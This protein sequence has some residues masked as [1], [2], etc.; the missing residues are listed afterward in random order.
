MGRGKPP[1]EGGDLG[2][3]LL[4]G[5]L[6]GGR[7]RGVT[8][9]VEGAALRL[10]GLEVGLPG[11]ELG[12]GGLLV[13]VG[14][15]VAAG[16]RGPR[17]VR[18]AADLAGRAVGER[19]GQLGGHPGEAKGG[20]PLHPLAGVLHPVARVAALVLGGP[21]EGEDGRQLHGRRLSLPEAPQREAE[22]L[23]PRRVCGGSAGGR[24]GGLD[25]VGQP[26]ARWRPRAPSPRR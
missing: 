11:G 25:L 13:G 2:G 1:V 16:G 9:A 7:G 20:E 6:A 15:R 10:G 26:A 24:S 12:V 17:V 19:P 8:A 21:E 4:G 3:Q 5:G 22:R 23:L 18:A 14:D